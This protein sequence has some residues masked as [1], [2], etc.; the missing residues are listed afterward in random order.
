MEL[1]GEKIERRYDGQEEFS[2][3]V[4]PLDNLYVPQLLHLVQVKLRIGHA[5]SRQA[6]QDIK[7]GLVDAQ[8]ALLFEARSS[9]V[10]CLDK[11][12]L[13]HHVFPHR[14]VDPVEAWSKALGVLT[15]GFHMSTAIAMRIA[16]VEAELLLNLG[17]Y[18]DYICL[19]HALYNTSSC[20]A[21]F[22]WVL[23]RLLCH[24][25][26]DSASTVPSG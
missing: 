17:L 26:Y 1:L 22:F 18:T 23:C 11:I 4:S 25:R 2:T 12:P 8:L 20:N 15:T 6:V 13:P 3:P 19:L 16:N 9:V 21:I 24:N 5:M 14:T 10:V 7:E